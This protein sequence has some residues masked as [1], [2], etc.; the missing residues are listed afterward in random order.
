[1]FAPKK[2]AHPTAEPLTVQMP[3]CEALAKRL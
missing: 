1:M 2:R 3:G